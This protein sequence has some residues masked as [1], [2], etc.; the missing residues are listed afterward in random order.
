MKIIISTDEA[1][2][3]FIDLTGKILWV[4][5]SIIRF[6]WRKHTLLVCLLMNLFKKKQAPSWSVWEVCGDLLRFFAPSFPLTLCMHFHRV[7]REVVLD[8][9]FVNFSFLNPFHLSSYFWH[10]EMQSTIHIEKENTNLV[11]WPRRPTLGRSFLNTPA[12]VRFHLWVEREEL[13]FK[14]NVC[15][16]GKVIMTHRKVTPHLEGLN[17][18]KAW[19]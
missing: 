16:F 5:P 6:M 19:R 2:N 13:F 17:R 18:E 3:D 8:E 14:T 12:F 4:L 10:C 1:G 15:I 9:E 7:K 11:R